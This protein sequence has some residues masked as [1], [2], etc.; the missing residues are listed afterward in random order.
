MRKQ[1]KGILLF[2]CVLLLGGFCHVMD[3]VIA[4][5]NNYIISTGLFC[6]VLMIYSGLIL[7]WLQ[8]V[9]RRLLPSC[10]RS[11][12]IAAGGMML[13]FLVL[14]TV[15][16]RIGTWSPPI[17]RYPLVL[18]IVLAFGI[19]T[20]DLHHLAFKPNPGIE[21]FI[22]QSGTYTH[23]VLFYAAYIW[24]GSITAAGIMHLF[25]ISR[26]MKD[27]KKAIRPFL[28]ILLI[29]LLTTVNKILDA[30]DLPKPFLMPE[31]M[32]FC[33]IGVLEFCIRNRLLPHNINYDV[34]F[35]QLELP[36]LPIVTWSLSIRAQYRFRQTKRR[37]F[38]QS[39]VIYIR[40][41]TQ[42]L[43]EWDY[44]QDMPFSHPMKAISTG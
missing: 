38:R 28:C 24:A 3:S 44:R 36:A 13:L 5:G 31:I 29:P 33:M 16:Y 32:I 2:V 17:K 41:R 9:R 43:P 18:G 11:Y 30:A 12:V 37:C 7:Y 8:S 25:G 34:Y 42:G 15:K 35:S 14:R 20:N 22:G 21:K 40:S 23:G 10:A 27:W 6:T 4:E 26:K 1:S 19:L 39:A